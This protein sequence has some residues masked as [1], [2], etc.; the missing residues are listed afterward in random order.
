MN[1]LSPGLTENNTKEVSAPPI[2]QQL[3]RIANEELKPAKLHPFRVSTKNIQSYKSNRLSLVAYDLSLYCGVD[4]SKT[5]KILAA[6]GVG[7]LAVI[8]QRLL[9]LNKELKLQMT[10]AFWQ[11]QTGLIVAPSKLVRKQ[12]PKDVRNYYRHL[13]RIEALKS[14]SRAVSEVLAVRG[15]ELPANDPAFARMLRKS[16][17]ELIKL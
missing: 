15:F 11:I 14:V 8:R 12:L 7:R 2:E 16:A 10:S 9:K 6:R 4:P 13:G 5:S 1:K 17:S 3:R